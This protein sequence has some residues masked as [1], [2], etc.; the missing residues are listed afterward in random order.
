MNSYSVADTVIL[1]GAGLAIAADIRGHADGAPVILSHGGGQTR[2]SWGKAGMQLADAGYRTISLDLRGHGESEWA[3]DSNYS[4][5]GFAGDLA[6]ILNSLGKPAFLVG[7]S[8][9]GLASLIVAGEHKAPV[10]G[11][12]LVDVA[13]RI[14]I[15]GAMQIGAFMRANHDGFATLDDAADAVSAYMPHRPRPKDP[16]GLLKNLRMKEDGRYHWHWDP[17]FAGREVSSSDITGDTAR[18]DAAT[19]A[20]DMPALLVRGGL[21]AVVSAESVAHFQALAPDAE[22][23]NIAGADHM[24]AGDRNDV[25]NEAVIDFLNRHTG[26]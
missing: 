7:A 5:D 8:L 11:L 22:V 4:L 13:P 3:A 2:F 10:A 14:E 6:A 18:L 20:L 26:K 19:R 15:E 25:F 21:S 16:S 23:M 17:K 9:G 24:V 1:K 12:V